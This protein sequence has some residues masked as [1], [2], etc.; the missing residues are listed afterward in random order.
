MREGDFLQSEFG[1]CYF[2]GVKP[3][4]VASGMRFIISSV[5]QLLN[6]ASVLIASLPRLL[7]TAAELS[8]FRAGMRMVSGSVAALPPGTRAGRLRALTWELGCS[9]LDCLTR[10]LSPHV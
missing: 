6:A 2:P 10:P 4:V 9:P 8:L 7:Q 5:E 1:G 3:A